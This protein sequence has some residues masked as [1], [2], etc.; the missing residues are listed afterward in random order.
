M[1][2]SALGVTQTSRMQGPDPKERFNGVRE[3]SSC[4]ELAMIHN[5]EETGSGGMQI[6]GGLRGIFQQGKTKAKPTFWKTVRLL[7]GLGVVGGMTGQWGRVI[8]RVMP[9]WEPALTGR[10]GGAGC[11][12]SSI[13]SGS[14][15][16]F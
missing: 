14:R 16:G 6:D 11:L 9:K 10:L 2:G 15:V 3:K 1:D 4:G 7:V 8:D 13:T 12:G 5:T